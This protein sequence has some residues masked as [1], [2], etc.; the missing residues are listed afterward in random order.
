M[1]QADSKK[2][3]T[4]LKKWGACEEGYEWTKA[5]GIQTF[6]ELWDKLPRQDWMVWVLRKHG[7]TEAH[8]KPLVL[9][10]IECA[11]D[12]LP[13]FE[14][15]RPNDKRVRECLE[16]TRGYV[17]GTVTLTELREKRAA[18]DAAYAAAYAAAAAAYAAAAAADDAAYAADAAAYAAA[19]AA[20]DAAY[21]AD[22]ARTQKRQQYA[23]SLRKA[24]P[25]PF[26]V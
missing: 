3:L 5:N 19:A 20:D 6:Q 18:D 15:R 14:K 2:V 13:L 21:A 4:Q 25:N 12:A 23:D 10:A 9:W 11:E 1:S 24:L 22:D 26:E 8:R 17:A 16:A 7:V